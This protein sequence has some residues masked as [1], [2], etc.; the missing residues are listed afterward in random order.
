MTQSGSITVIQALGWGESEASWR[1]RIEPGATPTFRVHVR[2]G[3]TKTWGQGQ[4]P[5]GNLI[6]WPH[7]VPGKTVSKGKDRKRF[8]V[9]LRK[10]TRGTKRWRGA[11]TFPLNKEANGVP[12][13][14]ELL[15]R[16]SQGTPKRAACN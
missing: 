2:R 15:H 14:Q 16:R 1:F 8:G 10:G 11:H 5:G 12:S 9:S 13:P 7:R 6:G 3:A 4:K